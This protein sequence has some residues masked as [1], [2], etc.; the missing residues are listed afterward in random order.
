MTRAEYQR[1]YYAAHREHL[2]QKVK[3][4]RQQNKERSNEYRKKWLNSPAGKAWREKNRPLHA[5]RSKAWREANPEKYREQLKRNAQRRRELH[6]PK[7]HLPFWK[8]PLNPHWPRPIA[9]A[10]RRLGW[11]VIELSKRM[12]IHQAQVTQYLRRYGGK[13]FSEE[14]MEQLQRVFAEAGEY[15]DVLDCWPQNPEPIYLPPIEPS[16]HLPEPEADQIF[17]MVEDL[18]PLLRD[19]LIDRFYRG[20][21]L[22]QSGQLMGVTR[23]MVRLRE[24]K[25]LKM[26]RHPS[27]L[28]QLAPIAES[29]GLR[30]DDIVV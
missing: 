21:T 27:R 16:R 5:A 26:L 12:G 6:P 3:I 2:K 11:T 8:R 9:E 25:A 24:A 14:R 23:E 10:M 28:R 22:E 29:I 19:A 4:W 15:V 20:L 18:K 1:A 7:N 17:H 30:V 13:Y